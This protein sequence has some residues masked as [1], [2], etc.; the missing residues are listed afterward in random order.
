MSYKI[1]TL[2][3]NVVYDRG[4]QA[5]H[6]LS[7]LIDTGESKILF[8]TGAS[9]L[10]IR[11]AE[12]LGIDLSKVD[13]LVLSHGHSDH[14]G[15][16]RQ[17]Q[18]L[19]PHAKVVCKKEALQKKYKDERE[20]GFK[21][22]DQPDEN[23]LWLV[24]STTEIVPG[25]HVLP[26][27]K[28]TDKSETHFEH[29]FTVKD[30][31]IVP[32][33]FEDELVLVLSGEKTISVLSSCS[34]RGITNIIRSAQEAFPER[35]LNVVIGGFHIHN[36]SEDKFNVISTYLGRKLPRRLGIC[37]CTGIDNY[38]RFHQEFST[39][40]FYNYTGWVEEIK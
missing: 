14:T 10:F 40:V 5:E 38:A 4:L 15:G 30:E 29:F 8:D 34:H 32:D 24:D 25:V 12:I 13:Y 11:N 23:R 37:H 19:N 27:I 28:I 36:A 39:R 9:D 2:V 17:F 31:N 35:T 3:D 33:T 21:K 7:L 18:E 1:T 6:G 22:A 26:Q 20:N 16:V